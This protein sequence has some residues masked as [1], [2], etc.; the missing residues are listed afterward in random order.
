MK[1]DFEAD[2]K[3]PRALFRLRHE[4]EQGELEEEF[5]RDKEGETIFSKSY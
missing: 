5:Y 1:A 2:I 3:Q 4:D